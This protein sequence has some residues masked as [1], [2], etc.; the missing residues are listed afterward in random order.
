MM[1]PSPVYCAI[2]VA[3]IGEAGALTSLVVPH[4]GGLKLGL[5]FFAANGPDGVRRMKEF[6]LPIFLDLKLHDIPNTVTGTVEALAELGID[7]LTIHTIG[8]RE[9]MRQAVEAAQGRVRLLGVTVLT[10]LDETDLAELGYKPQMANQVMRLAALGLECGLDGLVCSPAEIAMVRQEL[11]D[12]PILMVP[13]IRQ[14]DANA[15]DQ[16]RVMSP[17]A[18]MEAG[19][20]YL[21]IGRPI[22]AAPDPAKAAAEIG[23]LLG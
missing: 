2:D 14:A 3:D 10:S 5:T 18:A 4:V 11:G 8:G 20:T 16:K 21:V 13:G 22:T 19:A 23:M 17:E 12:E 9:M 7:Y 6:G 1:K 15:D